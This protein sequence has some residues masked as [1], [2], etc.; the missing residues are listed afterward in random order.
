MRSQKMLSRL[1]ASVAA[2]VLVVAAGVVFAAN[3]SASRPRFA[4]RELFMAGRPDVRVGA[5]AFYT[6]PRGVE[7]ECF[8]SEQTQSDKSD[9]MYRSLSTD[10]GKTWSARER[11]ETFTKVAGGTQ[12]RMLQPGW[13]DP[14]GVLVTIIMQGV[15]PNDR[16]LEGMQH[17]TLR[18]ALSRD[19]G[20]TFYHEAPIVQ[21]GKEY[22][23][24]HPLAGV[25]IGRNTAMLGDTTC[26]PIRINTGEIL[27]PVQVT[28]IGPDGKYYNPGG[29]Y[30]Y[31]D[32]A[33]LIG[34]WNNGGMLDWQLSDFVKA[35]P[36]RSTRGM[37][38]PTLAEMPDGKILMVM[39]G[40]NDNKPHL[41]GYR[42][43][44]VSADHGRTWSAPKPWTYS[45]GEQFYSPSSCSQL[46]QHSNGRLYWIGNIAPTNPRGNWPRYPLVA[47]EVDRGSMLLIKDS[48]CILDDVAPGDNAE[49]L[50]FSNF[51]AREDR[52]THQIVVHCSPLN[53]H[54][55]EGAAK[56]EGEEV[57]K[58]EGEDTAKRGSAKAASRPTTRPKRS[59]AFDWTADAYVYRVDVPKPSEP[60]ED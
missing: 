22:S 43:Y 53:Q 50:S 56:P 37:I 2:G 46:L 59:K 54:R 15:L 23:E 18:Y 39:R 57:T 14:N 4:G 51:Y 40:S 26:T 44:S 35:D 45:N 52:V 19:G 24:E 31:T 12:R 21:H 28:P 13:P 55:A 7:M 33:V 48:V 20:R 25:W 47:G 29:G 36:A 10:N 58:G 16:P 41:P 8:S 1:V 42:W 27:V 5:D 32:A 49:T 11:R 38:E 6:R 9:V 34:H 60:R 17:W 30:T 3:A